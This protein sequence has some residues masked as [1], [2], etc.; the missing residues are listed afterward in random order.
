MV[1]KSAKD[2]NENIKLN[3]LLD[4][5]LVADMLLITPFSAFREMAF[6][7]IIHILMNGARIRIGP[8][9]GQGQ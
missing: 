2:T 8:E 9:I 3:H 6:V 4:R 7:N 5:R 1:T